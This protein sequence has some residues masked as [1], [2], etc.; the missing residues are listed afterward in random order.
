MP[1]QVRYNLPVEVTFTVVP[2]IMVLVYFFFTARDEDAILKVSENPDNTISVV[3]HRWGWDFNY[4]AP[5]GKPQVYDTGNQVDPPTMYLPIDE[6]VKFVLTT[7]D[8]NHSFWV[9]AFDFKMDLIAG[10][11][12]QFEI[13]PKVL[14]TFRGKCAELC[15]TD[16]SRMLFS[17][18]I[19]TAEQYQA[20]LDDLQRRG[21][22]GELSAQLG[23]DLTR[24]V[25]GLPDGGGIG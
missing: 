21:N 14:G 12:N 2:L 15:G 23:S 8:V 16:H 20:H 7:R 22:T 17:V 3:G 13:V 25:S 10:R 4:L 19:V 5:D 24:G 11:T 18:K 1:A 6:S 9:P